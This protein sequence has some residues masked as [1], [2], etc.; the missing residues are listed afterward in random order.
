MSWLAST[1][2][3]LVSNP[4]R[5][6]PVAFGAMVGVGTLLLMLPAATT[7]GRDTSVLQALFTATS[8]VC[9]T[10]LSVV[11]T[12]THW[13]GFGQWVILVLIQVGGLGI[14]TVVTVALLLVS[15]RLGLSH[16]RML[17][18]DV[19]TDSYSDIVGVVRRIVAVTFAF[20]ALFA[21]VLAVRFFVTYD[22]HLSKAVVHGVFHSVSAWNNA[23]FAL[24]TD[25]FVGFADDWLLA[26]TL[27]LAVIIGGL[28]FPALRSLAAHRTNWRMWSLHTK[29]VMV[30][31]AVLLVVGTVTF[32]VFEWSNPK[33]LGALPAPSRFH[34]AFFHS[35]QTR[36][37]GFNSVDM[38]GLEEESLVVSIV[39]MFIGGGSASPAGGIKVTTFALLAFVIWAEVRGNRD[40]NAFRRRIS[41]SVQ[42]QAV[43]VA[44]VGVGV[45]AAS[46]LVLMAVSDAGLAA[47]AFETVSALSTVGLSTGIAASEDAAGQV[48][49]VVLMFIGRIGPVALAAAIT[50]RSRPN[51][52]RFPIDRPLIG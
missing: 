31:T 39:L 49:L 6:L 27:S 22:Y 50:L 38:A 21:V 2:S 44:L 7:A 48:L 30:T 46:T 51:L 4:F 10:G 8:A 25:N 42:R 15:D 13:T 32:L 34:A 52:F 47:A 37:A 14:V 12:A 5:L 33:T 16:T 3:V 20:E 1:R 26:V 41:E 29:L 43:T 17:A 23:G 45:L 36:T 19:R 40:V 35:A 9:V 11:D 28:G 18:A 24:Y